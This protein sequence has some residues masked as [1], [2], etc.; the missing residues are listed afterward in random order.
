[1]MEKIPRILES[2]LR[3]VLSKDEQP[4]I[5]LKGAFKEA[6]VCTPSRVIIAKAGFMTGSPFGTN[7]LQL[8]YCDIIAVE[9]KFDLISGFFELSSGGIQIAAMNYW[10]LDKRSNPAKAPNCIS[11][12]GSEMADKFTSA[13]SII[14]ENITRKKGG[15]DASELELSALDKVASMF[16]NGLLTGEEFRAAKSK[17]L[18]SNG[19]EQNCGE[20]KANTPSFE[21]DDS[22]LKETSVLESAAQRVVFERGPHPTFGR[23]GR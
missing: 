16:Q 7:V 20:T 13:C 14:M 18:V 8:P 2:R 6:L 4:I 3:D 22:S 23:R 11:I 15:T 1:M 21:V 12:T 10:S 17:L 5:K 19:G 9:V